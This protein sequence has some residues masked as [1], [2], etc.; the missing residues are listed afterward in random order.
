M[1]KPLNL[2]TP[3]QKTALV[4]GARAAHGRPKDGGFW[5]EFAAVVVPA[6]QALAVKEF[7]AH[8]GKAKNN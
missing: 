3:D 8:K 6:G 5:D 2:F 4:E 1:K 7:S